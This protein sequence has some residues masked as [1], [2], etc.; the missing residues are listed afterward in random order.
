MIAVNRK[1]YT[2][3]KRWDKDNNVSITV[4]LDDISIINWKEDWPEPYQGMNVTIVIGDENDRRSEN[5]P[6]D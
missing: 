6:R 1:V 2:Y 3:Q 5:N 4:T